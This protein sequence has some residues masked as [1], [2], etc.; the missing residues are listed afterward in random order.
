MTGVTDTTEVRVPFVEVVADVSPTMF[1][2]VCDGETVFT[3]EGDVFVATLP[4]ALDADAVAV[5]RDRLQSEDAGREQQRADIRALMVTGCCD[6]CEAL[7]R[8]VLGDPP[9]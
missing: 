6:L 7:A 3:R 4:A 1:A 5:V 9:E 2:D 8:F